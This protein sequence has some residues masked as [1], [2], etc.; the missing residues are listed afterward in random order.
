M[1]IFKNTTPIVTNGL[2]L[3]V[4]AGNRLSYVS[5][6]TTWNDLSGNNSTG[7]LLN[8]TT[9]SSDNQGTLLFDG[10]NDYVDQGNPPSLNFG[11]GS[12]TVSVWF[13][14]GRGTNSIY[15]G[16]GHLMRAGQVEDSQFQLNYIYDYGAIG[17]LW[18]RSYNGNP[19]PSAGTFYFIGS[20]NYVA[21]PNTWNLAT[22]TRDNSTVKIYVNG[23]LVTTV[24][25][26]TISSNN[27]CITYASVSLTLCRSTVNP[28]INYKGKIAI[29]RI[30]NRALSDSEVLQNF[31][32]NKGRFGI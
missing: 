3:Y 25:G 13:R 19:Y 5:G 30:Y 16:S 18:F 29:S 4:D 6:S 17:Y 20:P 28:Y 32:A 12:F 22:V 23:V 9:Y 26:A 7:S 10:I 15:D 11:T 21:M 31:N 8:G 14:R 27:S 24:T 1:A 2:V